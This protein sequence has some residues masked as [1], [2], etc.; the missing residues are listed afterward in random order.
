MEATIPTINTY[1]LTRS[2]LEAMVLEVE[3]P[4]LFW[5][6]LKNGQDELN[7]LLD[8]LTMRM[9]RIGTKL[10]MAPDRI[11][12]GTLVAVKEGRRWQRGIITEVTSH[13][14]VTIHLKDWG[15]KI[16]RRKFD[17]CHLENRFREQ[18][19]QAIPCGAHGI[20][21][22]SPTGWTERDIILTKA[23]IEKEWGEIKIRRASGGEFA[24]VDFSTHRP[25][26][27]RR[28]DL[29][30]ALEQAGAALRS[31]NVIINHI[32]GPNNVIERPEFRKIRSPGSL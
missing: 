1:H 20:R 29:A 30:H 23:L 15:R 2:F 25:D 6:K 27:F 26:D 21:P 28:H 3:S 32:I 5:V 12:V 4:T 13:T 18:P 22:V 14:D 31:S 24:E 10:T 8:Y 19:W 11:H 17:C 7:E 9:K 16:H